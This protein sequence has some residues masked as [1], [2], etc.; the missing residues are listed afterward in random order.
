MRRARRAVR[1]H[2][3]GRHAVDEAALGQLAA[4]ATRSRPG[5]RL[6]VSGR[7]TNRTAQE[8]EGARDADAAPQ[9]GGPRDHARRQERRAASR[10]AAPPAIGCRSSC[11]RRWPTA[12]TTCAHARASARG[13]ADCRYATRKLKVAAKPTAATRRRP[14]HVPPTPRPG[15]PTPQPD[16]TPKPIPTA[17]AAGPGTGPKFDVLVF[18]GAARRRSRGPSPRSATSP[19]PAASRSPR[20]RDASLFTADELKQFRAVVLLGD[21][22]S[23]LSAAQEGRVRGLLQGRRRPARGRLGDRVR[24]AVELPDRGAR[25]ARR[26]RRGRGGQRDDQGRRPRA[27]GEQV[28]ARVLD[29]QRPLLQLQGQRP[30][31][32]ARARHGR[33]EHLQPAAR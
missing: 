12:R 7:L 23:P 22:G 2:V 28:A 10:R 11:R 19:R 13:A 8:R 27:R 25:H 29:A 20:A 15:P 21:I 26:R 32:L 30:R 1:R 31:A 17:A 16:A 14:A 3:T 5:A 6:T 9:Q 24:A 33:R 18:T 4:Q